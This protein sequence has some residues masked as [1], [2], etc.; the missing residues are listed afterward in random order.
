MFSASVASL[1]T[2]P[3]PMRA[4]EGCECWPCLAVRACRVGG[5]SEGL[6]EPRRR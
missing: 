2:R 3:D 5:R 6:R 4:R 1:P